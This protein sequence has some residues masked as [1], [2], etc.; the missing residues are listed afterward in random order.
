YFELVARAQIAL[1]RGDAWAAFRLVDSAWPGLK[2]SSLLRLQ[3]LRVEL[4]PLR[5]R[6]SVP[7]GP[8]STAGRRSC[9]A[10]A[11]RDRRRLSR[12]GVAPGVTDGE[13]GERLAEPGGA[14]PPRSYERRE[15]PG[16]SAMDEAKLR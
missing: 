13:F 2:R 11:R 14:R 15:D 1:Y 10:C 7:R 12:H 6:V 4:L 8:P 3:L 5:A 9:W 16:S